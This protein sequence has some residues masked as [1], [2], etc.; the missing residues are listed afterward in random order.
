[1]SKKELIQYVE[2]T[3]VLRNEL[4]AF[5]SGDTITVHYKI[6]EGENIFRTKDSLTSNVAL[7]HKTKRPLFFSIQLC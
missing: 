4:P 5:K 2:D 6:K 3:L 1:M 7:N